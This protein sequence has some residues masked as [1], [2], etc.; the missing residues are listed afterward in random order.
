MWWFFKTMA[1]SS[2]RGEA[3]TPD[4]DGR[5]QDANTALIQSGVLLFV[6]VAIAVI[7]HIVPYAPSP[8]Y[9]LFFRLLHDINAAVIGAQAAVMVYRV[10]VWREQCKQVGGLRRD[11]RRSDGVGERVHR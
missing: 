11:P 6:L 9:T 1:A 8:E 5:C 10:V 4:D 3:R 7:L 2:R